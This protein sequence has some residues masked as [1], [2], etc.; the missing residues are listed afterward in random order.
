MLSTDYIRR[1]KKVCPL[2]LLGTRD[3]TPMNRYI[4]LDFIR[5]LA[6]SLLLTAHIGQTLNHPI[7]GFFFG[8][9]G[10]YYV[11]LGGVA[12]T[13]FL[14]LSGMVLELRY[15]NKVEY[16]TFVIKRILRLYPIY[17]LS[18]IFGIGLYLF[19][20]YRDGNTFSEAVAQFTISDILLSITGGYAFV[21]RWGGPFV[22]TSWFVGLIMTLYLMYPSIS[23]L[24]R[25]KPIF[26]IIAIFGCSVISRILIGRF[27]ILPNRPL[28]W[29]PLCRVFEFSI[30]IVLANQ[31]PDKF[32]RVFDKLHHPI[33]RTITFLSELSFPI[34]L[35][36]YPICF[37]INYIAARGVSKPLSIVF[38]ICLS[39]I[40]SFIAMKIDN[41]FP[42]RQIVRGFLSSNRMA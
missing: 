4:L 14:V 37:V 34:F 12:V 18:I 6:I 15:A 3:R 28:D 26:T 41:C 23:S 35:I 38:Y 17:Y 22:A 2:S 42:R 19:R 21:G 27:D 32:L 30:G 16:S 33:V 24:V 20:F 39:G 29:F 40:L 36:H 9:K 5:I 25:R 1:N 11:S 10:F 13:I 8:I 31:I 7:G